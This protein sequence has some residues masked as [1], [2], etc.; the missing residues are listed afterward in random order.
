[1]QHLIKILFILLFI[2]GCYSVEDESFI[3]EIQKYREQKKNEFLQFKDFPLNSRDLDSLDFYRPNS[4]FVFDCKVVLS[5]DRGTFHM[6][7]F[8]GSTVLYQKYAELLFR[9][10]GKEHSIETYT[11]PRF[12][13]VPKF[14]NRLFI[15]F[16]DETNGETT[17]GGGRYLDI[18]A[19]EIENGMLSLDFNKAYNPYCAYASGFKCPIPPPS[20]HL[21]LKI[22]AGEKNFLGTY[23]QR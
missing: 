10:N 5:Q 6:P 13:N 2:S 20:N 23:R 21:K 7:T 22:K 15:P 1:M 12:A 11:N 17:Y 18:D 14:R 4:K 9:N 19:S 16:K 3:A 8:D